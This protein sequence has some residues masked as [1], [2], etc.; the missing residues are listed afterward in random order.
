MGATYRFSCPSCA[1]TAEVSG[2]PDFGMVAAT[3]TIACKDCRE[4]YDAVD[5]EFGQHTQPL[6]CPQN[7]SHRVT[8]WTHPGSCPRC[9][10]GLARDEQSAVL[11]D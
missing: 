9:G 10:H 2:Q 3:T 11:W 5:G 7:P 4:L 6:L 1:Y 8:E